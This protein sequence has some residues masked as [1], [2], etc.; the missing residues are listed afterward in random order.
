MKTNYFLWISIICLLL[1]FS[2]SADKV[3]EP[4]IDP[5]DQ[6]GN[7]DPNVFY[8]ENDVLP[9]IASNCAY[10]GCHGDGSAEDGVDLSTFAS[11][12]ATAEVKPGDAADSKLYKVMIDNDPSDLMPPPPSPALSAEQ[13]NIIATWINQGAENTLCESMG[14][15]NTEAIT[16][17]Q[18]IHPIV[19]NKCQGCH[20]GGAPQGGIS[21]TNYNEI[22]I[23]VNSGRF[24]GSINHDP[25][26]VAMPLNT[27]KLPQC[28]ID[29]IS[30]WIAL[31]AM[32]D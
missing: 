27:A 30:E 9:I 1:I 18:H 26:Y 10:S 5:N 8:F 31:G 11:I 25:G 6:S 16:F 12:I 23:S 28:E 19:V 2:C 15:C 24:L 29:Q 32:N 13:I 17:S 4:I 22:K 3:A 14:S 7:C 20:S 21:L